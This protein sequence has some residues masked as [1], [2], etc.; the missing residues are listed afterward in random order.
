MT[1]MD[2]WLLLML[3][4]IFIA[5][6]IMVWRGLYQATNSALSLTDRVAGWLSKRTR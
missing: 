5:A 2:A 6:L 3:A 1:I 4:N